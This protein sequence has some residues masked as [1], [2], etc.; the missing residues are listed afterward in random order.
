MMCTI[1]KNRKNCSG[2]SWQRAERE[3]K[4]SS[5]QPATFVYH[6]PPSSHSHHGTLTSMNLQPNSSI[7]ESLP[8]QRRVLKFHYHFL[9]KVWSDSDS[10][11]QRTWLSVWSL[12]LGLTTANQPQTRYCQSLSDDLRRSGFLRHQEHS[13]T[14]QDPSQ[15]KHSV[16]L[17]L[18]KTSQ[19]N[20]H[21]F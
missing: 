20:K 13:I 21:N 5:P 6:P 1:N 3:R 17:S 15:K 14:H 11:T 8:S 7:R 4:L 9:G 19:I 18:F 2:V 12:A 16:H 10:T